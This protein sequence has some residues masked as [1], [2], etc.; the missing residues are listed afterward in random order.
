M[1][2]NAVVVCFLFVCE[3]LYLKILFV[4]RKEGNLLQSYY[5]CFT[6]YFS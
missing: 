1:N 4:I 3:L 5:S 2:L 6:L